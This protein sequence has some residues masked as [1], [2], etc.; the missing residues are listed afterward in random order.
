MRKTYTEET[1]EYVKKLYL[2]GLSHAEISR[3]SGVK[4]WTI[5]RIAERTGVKRTKAESQAVRATRESVGFDRFGKKGAVQS[6]K[7]GK[8]HASDSAYEYVRMHQHDDDPDVSE[9]SRCNDRIPYK[10]DG[11]SFFYVPDIRL[12][13]D[14]GKIIVEEVK[15]LKMVGHA[16]NIAKFAAAFAFYTPIGIQFRIVTEEDI[17][18]KNIRRFDG[19]VLHGIPDEERAA[20]QRA[21]SLKCLYAMSPEKRAAYN[22]AAKERESK[23]RAA[24]RDA[25][26]AQAREYRR[27]RKQAK[28]QKED[29]QA[30]L[31]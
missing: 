16:K 18:W 30:G 12:L 2:D 25:Y 22:L 5:T 1:I 29:S 14:N 17:G 7:N 4:T 13:M 24:N 15:P 26:N 28:A 3:L 31:F 10:F 19:M 20:K 6:K 11:Q 21:A 9:W 27:L 23:K 8:W